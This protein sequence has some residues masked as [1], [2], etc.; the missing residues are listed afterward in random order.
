MGL[1]LVCHG[2]T[3]ASELSTTRERS[4]LL[5]LVRHSLRSFALVLSA[6]TKLISWKHRQKN[7]Y[8]NG[9]AR[10]NYRR[11]ESCAA[12]RMFPPRLLRLYSASCHYLFNVSIYCKT[13]AHA[14]KVSTCELNADESSWINRNA[15][16]CHGGFSSLLSVL[17]IYACKVENH[18][19]SNNNGRVTV[20]LVSTLRV[21]VKD[22]ESCDLD[23]ENGM[24]Y[25]TSTVY[26]PSSYSC[27]DDWKLL[28]EIIFGQCRRSNDK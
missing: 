6:A 12:L 26:T 7:I 22:C 14:N 2:D 11:E 4:S 16:N 27:V 20:A 25:M 1:A 21:Y 9:G 5:W 19:N 13:Y 3:A 8:L 10:S 15:V 24:A 17:H 23:L 28:R 18:I